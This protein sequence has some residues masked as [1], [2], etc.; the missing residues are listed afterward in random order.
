M[1]ATHN[2]KITKGGKLCRQSELKL[3]TLNQISRRQTRLFGKEENGVYAFF[4]LPLIISL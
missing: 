4:R 1:I 3:D 2:Y